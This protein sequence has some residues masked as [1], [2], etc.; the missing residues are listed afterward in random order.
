MKT[1]ASVTFEREVEICQTLYGHVARAIATGQ[2]A[3]IENEAK[4]LKHHLGMTDCHVPNAVAAMIDELRA[5]YT[6]IYRAEY[7]SARA[8]LEGVKV[9]ASTGRIMVEREGREARAAA[10]REKLAN[11][12]VPAETTRE[13]PT[14]TFTV[15]HGGSD[16]YETIK[17]ERV[18]G[19]NFDGKV[20][21]SFIN[22]PDN[23]TSFKGFCFINPEN[24][25]VKVWSRFSGIDE[26]WVKA[27][28]TVLLGDA[29]DG[30]EAYALRSGR[31][32]RCNR[33]LTVPASL[34][35]GLGPDCASKEA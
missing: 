14:G 24:L 23:E 12:H 20:I 32:S 33:K 25:T 19:G 27:V 26:R 11:R 28:Q 18:E 5:A 34:H 10:N 21:A 9:E 31:C 3:E 30:R 15:E 1:V 6:R 2:L 4:L 35:R 29:A 16:V 13:I 8:A 22:G 17:I 7:A